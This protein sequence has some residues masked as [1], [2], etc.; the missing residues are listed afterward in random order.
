MVV[1]R[2]AITVEENTEESVIPRVRELFLEICRKN[3][4]LEEEISALIISQTRDIT[5]INSASALRKNG[6]C[7]DVSLFCVQEA[8]VENQLPFCIRF[9]VWTEKN[10]GKPVHVYL[11][12]AKNLRPELALD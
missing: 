6:L 10:I 8:Y 9:M 11:E 12:K 1:I 4:L 3:Q 7:S 5:K 2:G